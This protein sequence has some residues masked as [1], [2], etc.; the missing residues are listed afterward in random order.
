[1][2]PY[3]LFAH[4]HFFYQG[5]VSEASA[6]WNVAAVTDGE[7][8][9]AAVVDCMVGGGEPVDGIDKSVSQP[10]TI[11][12][13]RKAPAAYVQHARPTATY[14]PNDDISMP[15][16]EALDCT[17]L[18]VSGSYTGGTLSQSQLMVSCSSNT[19]FLDFAPTAPVRNFV[20]LLCSWHS[21]LSC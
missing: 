14:M 12:I 16:D 20:F 8:E 18:A 9:L 10:V 17:N 1:V 13:D 2:L 11:T 15:F 5:G 3:R 19:V 7:Y 4:L 6:N 21:L